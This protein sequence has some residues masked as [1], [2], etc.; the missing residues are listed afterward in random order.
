MSDLVGIDGWREIK[1]KRKMEIGWNQHL[2]VSEALDID[3][4]LQ[5]TDHTNLL[6]NPG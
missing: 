6:E 1:R 5:D 4:K 2:Q 3:W